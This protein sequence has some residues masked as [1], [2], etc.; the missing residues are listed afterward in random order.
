ML[1]ALVVSL[2]GELLEARA[3]AERAGG[4]VER[5][6]VELAEARARIAELEARA[7]RSSRNS[8]KPPSSDGLDKPAPKPRSLRGR[9]GRRPGGQAGHGGTTLARVAKPDHEV[10]HEPGCCGGCRRSLGDR[11]VTGVERRQRFDLPPLTVEVTEHQLI[12]PSVCA[13]AAPGAARRRG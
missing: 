1:A 4:E 12:E 13:G 3:A 8:S 6:R 9:T 10:V 5:A 2:R 7:G 11:P